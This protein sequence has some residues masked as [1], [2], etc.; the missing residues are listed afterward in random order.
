MRS[1]NLSRAWYNN[2]SRTLTIE[3]Q[4]GSRYEYFSVPLETY[5]GLTLAASAG[6]YLNQWIKGRF[7]FRE[8]R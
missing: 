6:Q 3:F 1:T 2:A 4:S 7:D 5:R 8:I